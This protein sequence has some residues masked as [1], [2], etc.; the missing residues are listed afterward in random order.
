MTPS[1]S[2]NISLTQQPPVKATLG[3]GAAPKIVLAQQTAV[4]A[5]VGGGNIPKIALAQQEG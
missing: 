2:R 3:G 5:V 1:T 4:K